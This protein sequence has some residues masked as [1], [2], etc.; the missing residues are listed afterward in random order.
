MKVQINSFVP[1]TSFLYPLKST[2]SLHRIINCT[3][4][5]IQKPWFR[6]MICF[7]KNIFFL[8]NIIQVVYICLVFDQIYLTLLWRRPLSHRNQTSPLICGANQ[9]TGFYMITTSFMKGL[10]C[11]IFLFLS[12]L[13]FTCCC[14]LFPILQQ[15]HSSNIMKWFF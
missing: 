13:L 6:N 3:S 11:D 5:V 4:M 12:V 14:T 10:K 2:L 7:P 15:D 8:I 9:W 1:N